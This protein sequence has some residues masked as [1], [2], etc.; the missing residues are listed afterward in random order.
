MTTN[1]LSLADLFSPS[2]SDAVGTIQWVR[3]A[4]TGEQGFDIA[5]NGAAVPGTQFVLESY[6]IRNPDRLSLNDSR[7]LSA[8]E[9]VEQMVVIDSLP[10]A[11]KEIA[12]SLLASGSEDGAKALQEALSTRPG[13][14]AHFVEASQKASE[15]GSS[16]TALHRRIEFL[17]ELPVGAFD[18]LADGRGPLRDLY[19]NA[20]KAFTAALQAHEDAKVRPAQSPEGKRKPSASA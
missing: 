4:Q 14:A 20:V 12:Y 6:P 19:E 2:A 1:T 3:R 9:R 16:A 8:L 15:A 18:V 7:K 17:C 10:D 13:F 11:S 5:D